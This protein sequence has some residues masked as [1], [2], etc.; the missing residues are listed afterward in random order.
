MAAL[1]QAHGRQGAKQPGEFGYFGNIGLDEE[2]GF[3]R[4][5]SA[6]Q[7]IQRDIQGILAP[8]RG[9]EQRGHGMVIGDEIVGLPLV[10]QFDRRLHHAEIIAQVQRARGLN[11]G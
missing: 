3:L 6:G 1:E 5:Q 7:E 9:I 10:L 11:A 4:V 8:L 2:Y